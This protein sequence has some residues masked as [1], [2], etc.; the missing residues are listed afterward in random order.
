MPMYSIT[1][2]SRV[3]LPFL[4]V[5][6]LLVLQMHLNCSSPH[7]REELDLLPQAVLRLR[8]ATVLRLRPATVLR[9]RPATVLRLR[10]PRFW[11]YDC[12]G[13]EITTATVLRLPAGREVL[14]SG[15]P[16]GQQGRVGNISKESW[17]TM[18][19]GLFV[20]VDRATRQSGMLVLDR[21][22]SSVR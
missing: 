4:V 16:G 2:S 6:V 11:D 15:R 21:K 5:I 12:H 22:Q 17:W 13:F 7:H 20:V 10:L 9:L 3:L 19:I 1:N 18:S 14:V 8:P